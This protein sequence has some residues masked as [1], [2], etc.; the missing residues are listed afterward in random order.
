MILGT[1]KTIKPFVCEGKRK[2]M[3]EVYLPEVEEDSFKGDPT[4]LIGKSMNTDQTAVVLVMPMRA[5]EIKV[6][7]PE[8]ADQELKEVQE[9]RKKRLGY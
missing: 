8:V 5:D 2:G 7:M 4:V 6:R 3:V 1:L 9:E